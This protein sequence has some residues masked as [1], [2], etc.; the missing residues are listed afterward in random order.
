MCA[1]HKDTLTPM[2]EM[3]KKRKMNAKSKTKTE[4]TSTYKRVNSR[5]G[6][7]QC[8]FNSVVSTLLPKYAAQ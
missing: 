6:M 8:F 3:G 5:D 7:N 4:N 1:T 2:T